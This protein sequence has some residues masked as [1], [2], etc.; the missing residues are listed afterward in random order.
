MIMTGKMFED[1]KKLTLLD[2]ISKIPHNTMDWYLFEING[3]GTA[4]D[5][6]TMLDFEELVKERDEGYKFSWSELEYFA[7]NIEDI[8]DIILV[9]S[10]RPITFDELNR[11]NVD[12]YVEIFDSNSWEV[13]FNRNQRKGKYNLVNNVSEQI[14][15]LNIHLPSGTRQTIIID[16]RGQNVSDDVL[17]YVDRGI[18]QK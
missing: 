14:V 7:R 4:P 6:L 1:D 2:V 16:I 13:I 10:P 15:Q 11:N 8:N 17:E 18:R 5:N 9:S 12:V 3:V